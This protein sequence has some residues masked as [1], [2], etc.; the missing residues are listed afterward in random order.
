[1][2]EEN[3]DPAAK[4]QRLEA[5]QKAAFEED[6]ARVRAAME[7]QNNHPGGGSSDSQAVDGALAELPSHQQHRA[8]DAMDESKVDSDD[9][10]GGNWL[11]KFT[12]HHTRVGEQYQVTELPVPSPKKK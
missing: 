9:D 2:V 7:A 6:M 10:E 1:M 12:P 4:R 5:E 3:P 11:N 8:T